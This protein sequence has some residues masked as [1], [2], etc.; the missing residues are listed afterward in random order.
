MAI[1]WK[2][3][4]EAA[5]NAV[6]GD[7][8]DAQGSELSI[9]MDFF[10]HGQRLQ[11]LPSGTSKWVLLVHGMGCMESCWDFKNDPETDYG[12]RLEADYGLTPLYLRYN[13]GRPIWESGRALAALL[14]AAIENSPVPITELTLIGH[15]L[16]GL[17]IR[18][19]CHEGKDHAWSALV[20]R[21]FYIGSPH[22]G[23]PWER[24]GRVATK[25]MKA[26]P[27]PV[28]ELIGDIADVRSNAIK[29]LGDGD[30]QEDGE[31]LPLDPRF[32]HYVVAGTLPSSVVARLI[33]DGLVPLESA[34]EAANSDAHVGLFDG[35]NHMALCNDEEVYTWIAERAGPVD[36]TTPVQASVHEGPRTERLAA[37]LAL[38]SEAVEEGAGA[39]QKVQ[40]ALTSR[41]YDVIE[42]VPSL[43][44]PAKAVRAVHFGV[45]RGTY[46]AVKGVSALAGAAAGRKRKTD[47][48]GEDEEPK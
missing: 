5:L 42:A 47:K 37:T 11:A 29:N 8:L 17:V 48:D 21:A 46:A 41:P 44:A 26:I 25:I 30:L 24:A 20:Q 36:P 34:T 23:S 13:T 43:E 4:G 27:D 7:R 14:E 33:G 10:D 18:S 45:M 35:R 38:L 15:S 39:V 31:R 16:G 12:R 28:V 2:D 32:E 19:A 6:I 40:E 22:Q 9:R 1:N 3:A